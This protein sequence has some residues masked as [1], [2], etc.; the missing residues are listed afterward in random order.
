[1]KG[2]M[3]VSPPATVADCEEISAERWRFAYHQALEKIIKTE[4]RT[5]AAFLRHHAAE[6]GLPVISKSHLSR[7]LKRVRDKEVDWPLAYLLVCCSTHDDQRRRD[8]LL[9]QM[10]GMYVAATGVDK[11][12]GY[13]GPIGTPVLPEVGDLDGDDLRPEARRLRRELNETRA[14]LSET[15]AQ[16]AD[17][18]ALVEQLGQEV[19]GEAAVAAAVRDKL[20]EYGNA[21][22]AEMLNMHTQVRAATAN[23]E[24]ADEQRR[25]EVERYAIL[26]AGLETVTDVLTAAGSDLLHRIGMNRHVNEHAPASWRAFAAYVNV[27]RE[28]SGAS[29]T[30]LASYT[31]IDPRRLGAVLTAR[32]LVTDEEATRIGEAVGAPYNTVQRFYAATVHDPAL[33]TPAPGPHD[34]TFISMI[35]N[36]DDSSRTAAYDPATVAAP[37][38]DARTSPP[39]RRPPAATGTTPPATVATPWGEVY[40]PAASSAQTPPAT[41]HG[42]HQPGESAHYDAPDRSRGRLYVGATWT[43]APASIA[44]PA[45]ARPSGAGQRPSVPGADRSVAWAQALRQRPRGPDNELPTALVHAPLMTYFLLLICTAV[46][47]LGVLQ[48]LAVSLLGTV[49]ICGGG[50]LGYVLYQYRRLRRPGYRGRHKAASRS[51]DTVAS[52]GLAR[53]KSPIV[54]QARPH[55]PA[56]AEPVSA[57][58][59]TQSRPSHDRAET[60]VIPSQ[61]SVRAGGHPPSWPAVPA[62]EVSERFPYPGHDGI[63]QPH[64]SVV[65]RTR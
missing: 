5:Q 9:A 42:T 49:V 60:I 35:A 36:S 12:K 40:I 10:A 37:A 59:A 52:A 64:G 39:P 1:M 21:S 38:G 53:D 2:D 50:W 4:W 15:Q 3:D 7:Q 41:L 23:A 17:R 24:H 47:G 31:G 51:A 61:R 57:P 45:S 18:D 26:T 33:G 14:R 46:S 8:E 54:S 20:M 22:N 30:V 48:L 32:E 43:P 16:L 27:Y 29:V 25:I 56:P 44:L 11:V 62:A 6:H 58:P 63:P 13:D 55:Q 34:G 65:T 19:R 28:R